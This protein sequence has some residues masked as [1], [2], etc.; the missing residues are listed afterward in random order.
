MAVNKKEFEGLSF[1]GNKKAF[2]SW[3]DQVLGHL[4]K[5]DSKMKVECLNSFVNI[6]YQIGTIRKSIHFV[7]LIWLNRYTLT[8]KNKTMTIILK[9]MMKGPRKMMMP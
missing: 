5:E 1:N 9:K 4:R 3:K 8:R 6:S 2:G 7:I